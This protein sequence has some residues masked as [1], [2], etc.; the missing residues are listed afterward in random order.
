MADLPRRRKARNPTAE[1]V[2]AEFTLL[3]EA[4][5][6]DGTISNE[7]ALQLREWLTANQESDLPSVAFLRTAVDQIL[8][9]GLDEAERR[10][11]QL[12]VEKALPPELRKLAKA[13][14]TAV[15]MVGKERARRDQQEERR[16]GA[17]VERLDFMVRGVEFEG[18]LDI[19]DAS[20]TVGQTVL[21]ARE[22]GNQFDPNAIAVRLESGAKIGYVPRQD[23]RLVAKMLDAG[24]KHTA[25]C[26]KIYQGSLGPIP[27]VYAEIFEPDTTVEE[28]VGA[29]V[30]A[31]SV[32]KKPA[33]QGGCLGCL[34]LILVS[35]VIFAL[36][37]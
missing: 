13:R 14:R 15:E 16:R 17:P 4:I 25:H 21:L 36:T 27:V 18:R 31:A 35:L 37:R 2:A 23:A 20:L 11:L 32:A 6:A 9:D 29:E 5:T 34:L 30:I 24:Y 33:K 3:L 1:G 10:T 8:A 12:A 28:A 7:E 22:P 19:V 26:K